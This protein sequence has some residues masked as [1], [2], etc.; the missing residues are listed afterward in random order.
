[1][2]SEL[3]EYTCE[4]V[5]SLISG[6]HV[7]RSCVCAWEG[8]EGERGLF[9]LA[10]IFIA[11]LQTTNINFRLA[12]CQGKIIPELAARLYLLLILLTSLS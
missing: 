3:V 6:M 7:R 5:M 12:C 11:I 8:E 9:Y 4:C 2:T 10:R 1:M